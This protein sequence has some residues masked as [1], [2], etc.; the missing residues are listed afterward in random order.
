MR[1]IY[2]EWDGSEF[3]T[4]EHL[5][6]FSNFMEYLIEFG[7]QALEALKE[8]AEDPEQ[9]KIIEQWLEEGL[10]EK[11]GVRFKLTPRAINS[12]QRKA[13]MEVF[14]DL[15]ADSS[16]GHETPQQGVGG[17]RAEGT[18]AYQFGD[19]VSEV[20]LGATLRNAV[21]RSG[22]G[23]PIRLEEGDFE[24]HATESK[25]TCSTVILLDMS[26]S[27]S[28]WN[29]F[30]QAKRCAMAMFALIRQR[31]V[32]DTVDIVGFASA[33]E[34]ISEH[35]LP[36]VLPKRISM[37]DPEIRLRVAISDLPSAPQHF[38]NLHMGLMTARKILARRGGQN[39]QVF[40]I[41]DGQPTAH[42]AGGYVHLLYPPQEETTLAT[43]TEA[44]ALTR[45]GVRFSTFALIED[46]FFMDWISFVDQLTKL[47]KGVAFYCTSG[48]LA[49]CVMESFLS[50]RKTKTF[51]F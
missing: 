2:Q 8:L 17:E 12:L 15:K 46:Y 36:L 34:V 49:N 50:G 23:L 11:A 3:P 22:P 13:L 6:Q 33:A 18:R 7:D 44:F 40:I 26:G 5:A 27:M 39:K 4:Q 20:N 21:R 47:T 35:K 48:D 38:T 24:L 31:F 28:R 19:P 32:L 29:R 45:Q 9:R 42:V 16:E 30:A 43:L 51:L 41:T 1:Y 37:F 25:A 14:S 10:L